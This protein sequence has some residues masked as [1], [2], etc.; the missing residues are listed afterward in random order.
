MTSHETGDAAVQQ[1]LRALDPEV[2]LLTSAADHE[3]GGL[4]CT[5]VMN[6]SIVP[7]MPRIVV[8]LAR[9]HRTWQLVDASGRFVLHLLRAD[10]IEL[11]R[12]F[13]M[14]SQR[15]VDKFAELEVGRSPEGC[16]V[17][18]D[19]AGWLECRVESGLDAGD[20]THFLAEVTNGSP[21]AADIALLRMQGL[22]TTAPDEMRAELKRQ[23]ERDGA[24]DRQAISAW[25]AA[26]RT[27]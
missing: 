5:S 11:V 20:R 10:Q 19:V 8:G 18:R 7:D 2:W 23:L 25:R 21:P 9:Q 12:R 17:L 3:R 6:A 14:Q 15:D 27:G 22:L 16:P 13:G 26:H 24:I 1:T 4:I